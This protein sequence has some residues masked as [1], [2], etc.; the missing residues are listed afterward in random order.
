[1]L[2]Q[3]KV[4]DKQPLTIFSKKSN[5][6]AYTFR[7]VFENLLGIDIKLTDDILYFQNAARPKVSYG[8]EPITDEIWFPS[9]DFLFE[10]TIE[11]Q[12]IKI[13][14][15]KGMPIF[16]QHSKEES[17]LKFD[18]FAMIFYLVSRC[19]EYLS[20]Q[21]DQHQRFPAEESLAYQNN[22]LDR[23]LVDEL[24][25]LIKSII[26]KKYP[27]F[28]FPE[29]IFQFTP[30]YDIDYAWSYL[31]KG[32]KRTLGGTVRDILKQPKNLLQRFQVYFGKTDPYFT[33]DYLDK[34]H[35]DFQITPIYFFLVG[36][37]GAFDKNIS[38][39]K[40]PFQQLIQRISKENLTGLHPSYQ[41]NADFFILKKEYNSFNQVISKKTIRSRQHFLKLSFPETYQNLLRLGIKEDYTMGYAEQLGFRASISRSFYWFDLQKNEATSLKIYP[42][43]L[44]DVT[45]KNYLKLQPKEAIEAT[46]KIIQ[47]T[48]NVNGN[49]ISIWH[50]NSFCEQ[51][52]W[53]GWR[54]VYNEQFAAVK[55][56]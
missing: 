26:Q 1:M 35:Q 22:F 27:N 43:Q 4:K 49:L 32:W 9:T 42:F 31:H 52:G 34:L 45:L 19:E 44:M 8:R 25:I 21:K 54:N 15:W 38:I 28:Q 24:A 51:E 18:P 56:K 17:H 20:N 16:F 48:K 40:K 39:Q 41:S 53:Q 7:L 50:N 14:E 29:Q 5:R 23:P 47:N 10:N 3:S 13:N 11:E 36:K 33:F 55:N 2:E 37:H 6:I 46:N 30:T 12:D